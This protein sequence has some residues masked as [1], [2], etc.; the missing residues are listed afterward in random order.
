MSE[1]LKLLI[2]IL[3][4]LTVTV[5][6]TLLWP[7]DRGRFLRPLVTPLLGCAVTLAVI[8]LA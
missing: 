4:G 5:I 6:A 1:I 7:R 3:A 8:Y 2:G